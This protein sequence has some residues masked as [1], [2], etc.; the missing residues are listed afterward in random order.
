MKEIILDVL[1]DRYATEEMVNI[2]SSSNKI[3]LERRFW[4]AALKAQQKLGINIPQEGIEAYES[5]IDIIDV[6]AIR[7]REIQRR[8]DV[9]ARIETFNELAGYQLIHKPFTSRDLTD[10]VEQYQVFESLKLVRFRTVALLS[11]LSKRAQ[12]FISLD[13][14]GR[15]HNVHGQTITLGKRFANWAE[16]LLIAFERANHLI[17]N[18]PLR[19]IKG[20]MGTQ[21]DIANLLGSTKKV[22]IFE[23]LMR[24]HLGLPVLL[25]S[26]GQVYPRSID[27][28]VLSRLAQLSSAPGNMAKT[29]RLMAGSGLLYEGFSKN[30]KG[31]AGMPHKIN[32][33]TCERISGTCDVIGGFLFMTQALLGNQWNEGDVSCSIVRRVALPGGFFAIDGLFEAAMTV[34]DEMGVFKEVVAVELEN[35]L[36][37]LSTTKILLALI[38]Q[39]MGREDAHTVIR[40]NAVAAVKTGLP[41][42]FLQRLVSDRRVLIDRA[43]LEEIIAAPD[44]GSAEWQVQKVVKKVALI[45]EGYPK[46]LEYRPQPIL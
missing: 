5:V 27:F 11:R 41:D 16:E 30:Q 20:P 38:N 37:F 44:H 1:A 45:I 40:D 2:W 17:E 3:K 12:E 8:H 7:T 13:M 22:E 18:Y 14:A 43:S 29:M 34:L 9:I 24:E 26:V 4:I 36:P 15:S 19:G 42:T 25:D 21:Q 28:E 39:G 6:G 23:E 32:A 31:S 33:R 35:Q 10:C 46:A